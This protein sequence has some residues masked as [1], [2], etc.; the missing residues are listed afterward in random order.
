MGRPERPKAGG[1]VV[2]VEERKC[3]KRSIAFQSW[4]LLQ[5]SSQSP[6]NETA[7]RDGLAVENTKIF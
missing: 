1:L 5:M 6:G 2:L 3:R 7:A 4:R